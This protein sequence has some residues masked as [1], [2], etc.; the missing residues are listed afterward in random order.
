V[1]YIVV[2]LVGGPRDGMEL[3]VIDGVWLVEV[4]AVGG[5][6]QYERAMDGRFYWAGVRKRR[7]L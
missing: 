6:G 7:L 5:I 4:P 3:R 2:T 1:S